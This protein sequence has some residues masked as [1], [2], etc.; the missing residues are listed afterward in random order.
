MPVGWAPRAVHA[1]TADALRVPYAAGD[2]LALAARTFTATPYTA[3][4]G[5]A[6]S[7]R[8]FSAAPYAPGSGLKL[9]GRTFS[10]DLDAL[11]DTFVRSSGGAGLA[12]TGPVTADSLVLR[13][14]PGE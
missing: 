3:G 4:D 2:G 1:A 6:L 13:R 12:L 10:A 14:A 5:L 7:A 9:D 11:D 8:A